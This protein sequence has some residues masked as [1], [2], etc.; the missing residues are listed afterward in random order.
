MSYYYSAEG[1]TVEEAL[2]A[3]AAEFDKVV[4]NQPVHAVEREAVQAAERALASLI[5]VADGQIV[6]LQRHGSVS[7]ISDS[8]PDGRSVTQV[9]ASIDVGA[10]FPPKPTAA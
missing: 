9:S 2:A 4:V 10:Y 1:K 5:K 6:R 7:W 3:S 8:S